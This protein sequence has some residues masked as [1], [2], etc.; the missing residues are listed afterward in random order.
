VALWYELTTAM[1]QYRQGS[2]P[3]ALRTVGTLG[4]ASERIRVP[5]E[6]G[7]AIV[8]FVKAMSHQQLGAV[9]EARRA[10]QAGRAHLAGAPAPGVDDLDREGAVNV[11]MAHI[12]SR[13]AE[14]L[15]SPKP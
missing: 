6:S 5:A 9:Q 7:L 8:D 11:L 4:G 15:V 3:Q 10:L 14:T 13:E 12:L 2:Y 1:L